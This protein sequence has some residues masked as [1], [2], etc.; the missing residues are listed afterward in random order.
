MGFHFFYKLA[1][2]ARKLYSFP[3]IGFLSPCCLYA[4]FVYLQSHC[5]EFF[6]LSIAKEGCLS[7]TGRLSPSCTLFPHRACALSLRLWTAWKW[8]SW[9][10]HL[11]EQLRLFNSAIDYANGIRLHCL[12]FVHCRNVLSLHSPSDIL[13]SAT[14]L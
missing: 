6:V 9:K 1:C 5:T 8:G 2:T 7:T 4:R 14:R 10:L 12:Y 13:N 11:C 3:Y